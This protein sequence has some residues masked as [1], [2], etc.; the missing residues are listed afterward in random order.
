MARMNLYLPSEREREEWERW[1][2]KEKRSL[3]QFIRMAV[4]FY[5]RHLKHQYGM[6]N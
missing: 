6:D 2:A 1:A 5:I 3:S 4:Q